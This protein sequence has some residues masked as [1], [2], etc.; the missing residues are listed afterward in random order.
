MST[1]STEDVIAKALETID[2]TGNTAASFQKTSKICLNFAYSADNSE[3]ALASALLLVAGGQLPYSE[4]IGHHLREGLGVTAN[5][6]LATAWQKIALDAVESGTAAPTILADRQVE[7]GALMRMA[8]GASGT[9]PPKQDAG[10]GL[11]ELQLT[12]MPIE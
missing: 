1:A 12:V 8:L 3:E 7:R 5:A 4:L 6:E 11:P 2:A 9:T 10:A